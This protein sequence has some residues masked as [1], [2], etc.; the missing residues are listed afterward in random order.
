MAVKREIRVLGIDDASFDK[1]NDSQVTVIGVLFRGG[2]FMDGVVTT[3]VIIDGDDA[4]DAIAN[5]VNKSKFRLQIQYIFM[6]G[7][8]VAG[9]NVVDIHKLW[10]GTGIPVIV[11][12]RHYPDFR[13]IKS[14]LRKLGMESKISL[15]ENAGEPI[16]HGK[17][18]FQSAGVDE[19]R[20]R[21]VLDITSTHSY[22]PEPIRIAHLIG[23]GL[24][25]GES[26][27]GA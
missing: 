10:K 5:M 1:H 26:R 7:I 13:K 25:L 19:S 11:V 8:A 4:T 18:L 20:A 27:G 21:E 6:D 12:T 22:I 3:R 14:V 9:F 24:I 16:R 17:I 2:S 23:Q 15:I